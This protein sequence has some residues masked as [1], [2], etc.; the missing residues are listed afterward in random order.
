[1]VSIPR[2]DVQ[3]VAVAVPATDVSIDL[4]CS[5]PRFH[6]SQM[7][8]SNVEFDP[9]YYDLFSTTSILSSSPFLS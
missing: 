8:M 9:A 2:R 6:A 5:C 3:M 1:M 4:N 7:F